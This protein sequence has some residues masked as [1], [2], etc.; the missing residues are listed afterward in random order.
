MTGSTEPRIF[1]QP[2]RELTPETSFGFMACEYAREVMGMEL[3]PWQEWLLRHMLEITGDMAGEWRFR[4]RTVLVMVARQNGKTTL[5]SVLVSFF[6]NV[7][8]VKRAFGTS[9]S[10]DKA[11]ETWEAV[12]RAQESDP[13][14]ES[15]IERVKRVNGNKKLVLTGNREYAV[16]APSRRAGR[17]DAND[18]VLLDE[19]RE[20]RDWEVWSA[21]AAST[22]AK[23][24]GIVVCF[25]NAGDPDSVVLRQLRGQAIVP[26]GFPAPTGFGG[27][28]EDDSTLGIF[29]WSAPDGAALTDMDALAAANPALGHGRL[30][31][32]ALLSNASTFPE[33]KFRAECLCQQVETAL[34]PPFPPGTWEAGTDR[35]SSIPAE[36]EVVY[37]I[38]L[39]ADRTMAAIAAAG[40]R[41]DGNVHVE[42]VARNP[43]TEWAIEWFRRRAHLHPM[44]LAF[45]GRGAPG[46][47]LA[48]QICT[49]PGVERRA[50]EGPELTAGYGRFW[51]AVANAQEGR[52]GMR[53][54]HL[55]Q[56]VLDMPARTAQTRN[57]GGGAMVLD[58]A[59]SPDDVA[60]LMACVMA[61]SA[62]TAAKRE[63]TKIHPSAYASGAEVMFI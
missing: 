26:L 16:G 19:L 1:T 59:K 41:E 28:V 56:P 43:G 18:L 44:P 53:V 51:D 36:N 24:N 5:A 27:E 49:I 39:S 23:P 57:L 52:G 38:D 46:T 50:V 55:P 34:E 3:Y 29:E 58:R 2:L 40:F 35:Q 32:R 12:V 9:L 47:G 25:S 13:E 33:S 11:E 17:G 54:Y 42:V 22:N 30:T 61:F 7:L 20:H 6:L 4:F 21:A 60:P 45:Q 10:L 48:E 31:E 62:L 8:Q 63:E 37:G 14:L 15:A